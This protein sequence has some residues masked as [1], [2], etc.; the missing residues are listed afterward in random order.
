MSNTGTALLIKLV[1][2]FVAAA[3]AF[4]FFEANAWTWILLVSAIAT[5]ANYL[6]GDLAILPAAGNTVASI[7][8]GVMAAVVAWL[9]SF[10][11]PEFTISVAS[12]AI[13]GIV[14]A[15]AEYF[16][17]SYLKQADKVSPKS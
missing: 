13:F 11:V 5:A 17:H 9:V 10:F 12:L 6:V 8:D 15:V 3:I 7:M 1:L 14:V 2:T 4:W 16:F